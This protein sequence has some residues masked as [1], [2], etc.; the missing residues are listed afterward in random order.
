L[1]L[2]TNFLYFQLALVPLGNSQSRKPHAADLVAREN[3]AQKARQAFEASGYF[4]TM[5]YGMDATSVRPAFFAVAK[6]LF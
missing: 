6:A 4:E 2:L 5:V 3:H 1:F